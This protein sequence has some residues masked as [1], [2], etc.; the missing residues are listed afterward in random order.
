[1]SKQS[2]SLVDKKSKKRKRNR[3]DG[4]EGEDKSREDKG[5]KEI[6]GGAGIDIEL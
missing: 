4:G 2:S 3:G 5:I 6:E 1:M